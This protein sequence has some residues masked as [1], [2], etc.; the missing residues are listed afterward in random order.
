MSIFLGI[1][2]HVNPRL[3]LLD[4]ANRRRGITS[5]ENMVEVEHSR[6]SL[7]AIVCFAIYLVLP[8][9]KSNPELEHEG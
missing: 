6:S 4:T 8:D 2:F 3:F 7:I 5:S 1:V 9:S